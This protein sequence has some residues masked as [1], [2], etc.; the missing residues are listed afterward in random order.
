MTLQCVLDGFLNSFFAFGK[1][2]MLIYG[3]T[4]VYY[5]ATIS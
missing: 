5:I 3:F 4:P 2:K 1:Q